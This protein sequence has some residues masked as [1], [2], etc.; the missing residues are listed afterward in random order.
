MNLKCLI[1]VKIYKVLQVL[2]FMILGCAL[3]QSTSIHSSIPT[4]TI[5]LN[6]LAGTPIQKD[7]K[8]NCLLYKIHSLLILRWVNFI[9]V[10]LMLLIFFILFSSSLGNWYVCIVLRVKIFSSYSTPKHSLYYW[11]IYREFWGSRRKCFWFILGFRY[12]YYFLWYLNTL[13]NPK[14]L[15]F[16]SLMRGQFLFIFN[17]YHLPLSSYFLYFYLSK[18]NLFPFRNYHIFL[19]YLYNT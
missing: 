17:F 13:P 6:P 1:L 8:D 9:L 2:I 4:S 5:L 14:T 3:S 10:F 12:C 18:L 11:K 16:H 15:T 19:N 7:L